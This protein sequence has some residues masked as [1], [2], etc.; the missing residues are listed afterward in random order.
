MNPVG[1]QPGRSAGSAVYRLGRDVTLIEAPID[2][3]M[4]SF[5]GR[6]LEIFTPYLDGSSRYYAKLMVGCEIDGTVLTVSFER[7][8][9]GFWPFNEEQRPQ[10]EALVAAVRAARES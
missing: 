10:V 6:V 9:K 3:W 2:N 8:E 5:D 4:A 7:S 1:I